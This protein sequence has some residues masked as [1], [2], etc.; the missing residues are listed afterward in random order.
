M[1]ILFEI[2]FSGSSIEETLKSSEAYGEADPRVREYAKFLLEGTIARKRE[3]DEMIAEQNTTW[4]IDRF[5][6]VDRNILRVA[7][8]EL[9]GEAD[10]PA[11]VIL[12]EAVEIAKLFGSDESPGF[13]NGVLDG[14]RQKRFPDKEVYS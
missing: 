9:M 8:F 12:D 6:A 2:D 3:I 4:R 5:H 7:V 14:I 10:V 11:A 13:I 1:Q